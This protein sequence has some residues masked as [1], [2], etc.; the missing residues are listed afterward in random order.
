M[1]AISSLILSKLSPTGTL[2]PEA[3]Q[4][5]EAAFTMFAAEADAVAAVFET[6]GL[7]DLLG[8][9]IASQELSALVARMLLAAT[10]RRDRAVEARQ[11][12]AVFSVF[13][14]EKPASLGPRPHARGSRDGKRPCD[15]GGMRNLRA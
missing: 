10:C 14:G 8:H 5:L 2:T 4:Q 12:T 7:L 1:H 3:L 13:Q 6:I 15:F 9:T 11:K